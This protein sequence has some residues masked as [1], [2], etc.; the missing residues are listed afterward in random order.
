MG[1]TDTAVLKY[2]WMGMPKVKV[3]EITHDTKNAKALVNAAIE[4]EHDTLI[5][6][7]HGTPMGLLNPGFKGGAY[8]IDQSNYKKIRC[9]RIVAVWCHAKDFAET[10][11]VKGFWSSM[12]ISNSGEAS[13]NGIT[14]VSGKSITEQEIL[15]CV[16]L[17]ELIKNY[18]PM[19]TWIPKLK[20]QADYSNEVVKFN[21]DGLRYYKVAPTPKRSPYYGYGYG[22]ILSSESDR[23]GVDLTEDDTEYVEDVGGVVD[24]KSFRPAVYD[25][26]SKG[27]V[28]PYQAKGVGGIKK[29]SLKDAEVIKTKSVRKKHG[30][31]LKTSV[32]DDFTGISLDEE[33]PPEIWGYED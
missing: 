18:A 17:N 32:A 28:V 20:E 10:Y 14:S 6:C 19:K 13:M 8:L 3:V 31:K 30:Y 4:Q 24:A 21:Y 27:S 22:S 7:G 33:Y 9:N 1:D 16:R 23:W 5:M 11:G 25:G 12:F 2:I 29:T 15:F 26:V